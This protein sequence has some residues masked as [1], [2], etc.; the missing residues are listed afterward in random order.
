M[1]RTAITT[2]LIAGMLVLSATNASSAELDDFK[3]F[4]TGTVLEVWCSLS[5]E[6][7]L[8]TIHED[9]VGFVAGSPFPYV[10]KA[11]LAAIFQAWIAEIQSC[12]W[13]PVSLDFRVVGDIGIAFGH[14]TSVLNREDGTTEVKYARFLE[15]YKKEDEKWRMIASSVAPWVSQFTGGADVSDLAERLEV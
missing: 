7:I 15:V 9:I 4:Y 6:Q 1:N 3:A 5:K 11:A 13:N 2:T 10:G 8:D 12:Q 14:D